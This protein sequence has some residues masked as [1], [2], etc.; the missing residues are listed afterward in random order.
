M[1]MSANDQP[2][3]HRA[4]AVDRNTWSI[5]CVRCDAEHT[6]EAKAGLHWS[7]CGFESHRIVVLAPIESEPA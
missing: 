4:R 1:G 5:R 6:I 7:P 2:D 3:L